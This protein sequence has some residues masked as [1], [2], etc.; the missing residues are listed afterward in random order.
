MLELLVFAVIMYIG[1]RYITPSSVKA[2]RET[3]QYGE[4]ADRLTES[5]PKEV[6]GDDANEGVD[7]DLTDSDLE[8][9]C[10]NYEC[11]VDRPAD[12][13]EDFLDLDAEEDGSCGFCDEYVAE[14]TN[15]RRASQPGYYFLTMPDGEELWGNPRLN[16]DKLGAWYYDDGSQY[17]LEVNVFEL[18]ELKTFVVRHEIQ[19]ANNPLPLKGGPR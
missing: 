14:P 19:Q 2:H 18:D 13:D 1:L 9:A 10:H 7:E 3:Q 12:S 8:A 5:T 15:I 16:S 6:M 11:T 4:L 17:S